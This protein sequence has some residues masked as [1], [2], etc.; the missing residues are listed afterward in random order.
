[1]HKF[2]PT[3]TTRHM[4]LVPVSRAIK[5]NTNYRF[6]EIEWDRNKH[7]T[8]QK[9]R[10]DRVYFSTKCSTRNA[11]FVR[12]SRSSHCCVGCC[13]SRFALELTT[14]NQS[15]LQIQNLLSRLNR[16]KNVHAVVGIIR[17]HIK[18]ASSGI[19]ILGTVWKDCQIAKQVPL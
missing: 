11:R 16:I 9:R 15:V 7:Y 8:H 2:A 4:Y 14:A 18:S 5:G 6:H 13:L 3:H 19:D 17:I 1:M 12:V 10:R